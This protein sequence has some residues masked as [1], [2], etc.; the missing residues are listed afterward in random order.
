MMFFIY[1]LFTLKCFL[2]TSSNLKK[3]FF[4]FFAS[5]LLLNGENA[6]T[7][8]IRLSADILRSRASSAFDSGNYSSAARYYDALL[9]LFPKDPAYHYYLAL[10]LIRGNIDPVRGIE[11][12]K[13][14]SVAEFYPDALYW[15]GEGYRTLYRFDEALSVYA[16]C[17]SDKQISSAAKKNA[18]LARSWVDSARSAIQ[19]PVH[20]KAYK[21]TFLGEGPPWPPF[22]S[23]TG[24][25]FVLRT[26]PEGILQ[27]YTLREIPPAGIVP[28]RPPDGSRLLFSV[29]GRWP[30]KIEQ[31]ESV[32]FQATG[33]GDFHPVTEEK[34]P[35]PEFSSAF[36][37]PA[38]SVCY[39]SSSATGIGQ[40]DI[41]ISRRKNGS[42]SAERL[43]FPLNSSAD[44]VAF[45]V[46]PVKKMAVLISN[47][48]YGGRFLTAYEIAWPPEEER[49][50]VQNNPVALSF[51]PDR[52][53]YASGLSVN[54]TEKKA[55][56]KESRSENGK[57]RTQPASPPIVMTGEDQSGYLTLLNEALRLQLKSDS[58]M[59]VAEE[60]KKSLT[61]VKEPSE[62]NRRSRQISALFSKADSLQNL[63]NIRYSLAREMEMKYLQKEIPR[64]RP[65]AKETAGNSASPAQISGTSLSNKKDGEKLVAVDQEQKNLSKEAFRNDANVKTAGTTDVFEIR[66]VSPYSVNFPIPLDQGFPE[67]VLYRI[68]IGAY[69]KPVKPD[70]FRG[71][72]PVT[73]ERAV[74]SGI[75]RYYA[76]AFR[77]I[78]AAEKALKKV[79][80]YGFSEAFIVSWFQGRRISLIR[81]RELE[82]MMQNP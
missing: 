46:N 18:L 77:S 8:E 32:F 14:S 12:L 6:M 70:M 3:F 31:W 44:E 11:L 69:S 20:V 57:N 13:F 5:F 1:T 79:K 24:D 26:L 4:F 10:S 49:L 30:K 25:T 51:F 82:Q 81:A 48:K 71:L 59:R 50:F 2:I 23:V 61:E 27:R 68:Q 73:G 43:A 55:I 41:F 74:E 63:A 60:Q 33:W 80:E 54:G 64:Y 78:N 15:Q 21:E 75:I 22:I 7:Q 45:F 36:F 62:R 17:L 56:P 76:G 66:P 19:K 58:I 16:T 35:L 28:L 67:G 29:P 52:V 37:F 72:Y 65:P 39:V 53:T 38:D 34:W 40:H 42:Y 9:G 47:R